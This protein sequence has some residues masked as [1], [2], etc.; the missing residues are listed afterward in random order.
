DAIIG[1][2]QPLEVAGGARPEPAPH[3][4]HLDAIATG[5]PGVVHLHGRGADGA[6][7]GLLLGRRHRDPGPPERHEKKCHHQAE[8]ASQHDQTSWE[9]LR[10]PTPGVRCG[11]SRWTVAAL[12]LEPWRAATM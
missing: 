1:I 8:D 10:R 2:E 11:Q 12:S 5:R 9:G 6:L 7:G 4:V 3:E